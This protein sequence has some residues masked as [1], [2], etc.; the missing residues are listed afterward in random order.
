MLK[1]FKAF[2]TRGNVV[3][4]AVGVIVGAAFGRIVTSL[5]ND[6]VMPP[7]GLLLGGVNFT[8]LF[9]ALNGKHYNSLAEAQAA[10]APTINYGMFV[11]N[12]IDFL[13]VALAV[14]IL[15]RLVQRL[16]PP[17]PSQEMRDCPRCLSKI[18]KG[19][20]RCP[21]CTSKIGA[22]ED[23]EEEAETEKKA[24]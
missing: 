22:D 16:L 19:A 2:I 9:F 18:P 3:D 7:I 15:V 1:E 14:F 24:K 17:P 6:I 8:N 10:G 11:N 13:I 23:L 12:V 5:V 21:H 20:S 4:F